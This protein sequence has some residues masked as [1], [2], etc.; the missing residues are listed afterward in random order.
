MYQYCLCLQHQHFVRRFRLSSLF[1]KAFLN[2][3]FLFD[4]FHK[5]V[6]LL[7]PFVHCYTIGFLGSATHQRPT[8]LEQQ[9][10]NAER[11]SFQE[12]VRVLIFLLIG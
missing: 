3:I 1:T 2:K 7:L 11:N 8:R 12:R 4:G 6:L 10:L 5:S 9:Q